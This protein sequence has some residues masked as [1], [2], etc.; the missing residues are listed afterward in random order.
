MD[1][2][3]SVGS[4]RDANR[5]KCELSRKEYRYKVLAVQ[6]SV[7]EIHPIVYSSIDIL[8]FANTLKKRKGVNQ[9]VLTELSQAL[10]SCRENST[11]FSGV[12]GALQGLCSFLTGNFLSSFDSLVKLINNKI[13][14]RRGFSTTARNCILYCKPCLVGR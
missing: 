3:D 6:R 11:I 1:D 12:D 8:S 2:E 4:I 13:H 14:F 7:G 10:A 5:K 9:K